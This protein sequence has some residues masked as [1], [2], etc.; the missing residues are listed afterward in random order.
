MTEKAKKVKFEV[1]RPWFGTKVGDVVELDNPPHS[2]LRA[3]VRILKGQLAE[4][5]GGASQ[6]DG[7]GTASGAGGA[8]AGS[9]T[10]DLTDKKAVVAELQAR[11][12]QF[13][14]RKSVEEL[15]ELLK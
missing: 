3:N 10:V 1:I 8:Q 4:V 12:I 7:G 2:A 14:G 15:A 9:T 6:Q 11:N 5:A 13:D